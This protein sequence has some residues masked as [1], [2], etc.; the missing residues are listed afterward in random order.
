[1]REIAE[2]VAADIEQ[3]QA[4]R[5]A[6]VKAAIAEKERHRAAA[7]YANKAA[8]EALKERL[9]SPLSAVFPQEFEYEVV[10]DGVIIVAS[11]YDSK[12]G[13]G[14]MIRGRYTAKLRRLLDH[15]DKHWTVESLES[16]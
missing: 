10:E 9:K 4:A 12:N 11:H 6:I 3:K 7:G 8:Q 2:R 1:M 14:A 16:E 13:F 5:E 15:T